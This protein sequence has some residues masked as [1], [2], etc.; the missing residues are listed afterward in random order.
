MARSL[1]IVESPAKAK[2]INKYLGR[3]YTVKASI[4]HVMDLPKK[5]IG[6]RLPGEEEANGKKKRRTKKGGKKSKDRPVRAPITLDDEKL[7]EPTLQIIAGKGKV[8]NDLRKAASSADAVYLAADPDRE[9]EAISAHLA[10]VLAKPNKFTEQEPSFPRFKKKTAESNG[11]EAPKK[12]EPK[13]EIPPT[14]PKKIFR[15]TFNEITPKAIRAAFEHAGKIDEHLVDAQQ[16][17]RVLDR[18]VGYKISPLLWNKVRRGLSAGRVQ[19]VALRLIVE[20]ELEIRGF[21]PQ[22][23]WTIHATL[24]SGNPPQFEAKLVKLKGEDLEVKNQE[25]ADKIVAAVSKAKWQVSSVAQKEKRRNPPPPFTTSKLQQAAYNRLRYT[26]KRTMSLA[27]KLYEGVELGDEGSVALITYM[28]TDSVNVSNDALAQV[29]ELIPD[30]FGAS[31]LPEKPNFYKSKKDAQEAHEAVRPTDVS[32]APEDVRKY[33]DDDLFKLYQLIWQRFVASQMLPAVFDH[34]TIDI[35]ASDY[36]FRATGSVQK[37]DGYLRVYQLPASNADREDD[38]MDDDGEGKSLPRVTEGQALR[39]VQI[40]PDQHFTEPPPRYNDA[41]LVK[42][43]EEKGIGRPS[44]Y[45]SIIST[46]VER[47]YVTKDQGRFS[48]TMLG[49]RVS[50]LLVKSFEDIFDVTFT[51]RLEEELDNIEEGKLPWREAVKEFWEKFIVDL[52][53]ADEEMLSYKAGIATGK[54]CPK[55][56][57]GELLERISRHGFFLG[58]NRYPDCDFIEDLSPELPEE[59]GE[60]KIEYCDNCGKEMVIKRGRFGTFLACKGYPDCKT[61]RRLVQGT[62]IAHQPDEPLDEKCSLCGNGLVKKHG[63]FGEFIGCSNYPKCKYTRP[64][65]LGI[66]CPKC[67]EGEFVRR[68]SAGKGG[69]GRPRIFYGCSRYPDCDFT[70]PFMPIAEP[71]PKCGAPFIVE[72]KSKIGTVHTCLKEGCDWEKLAPEAAGPVPQEEPAPVGAKS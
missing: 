40:R 18:I 8:I 49:E 55:C 58:C 44:T 24:D 46:I 45:A 66:K 35:A 63:R 7:F 52:D 3:N 13:K 12:E 21:V 20:R 22:E 4:G 54:K 6:I 9:G 31:Y 11:Q 14:D 16:A 62:R 51:A 26:A 2:T 27:Q 47:E 70:T 29:R 56:G 65:T 42:E 17:R 38:E 71:C 1:V 57:Q 43:L 64:I 5:T 67:Q 19:T 53:R 36:T 25:A 59:T 48:P 61:T 39:L 15:V 33:L 23:Y 10:M 41:T 50:V 37:F 28:R 72:K 34:T 68:G 69:R 32:R 30:R 60:P